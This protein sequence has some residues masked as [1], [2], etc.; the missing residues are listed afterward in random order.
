ME[1]E[2]SDIEVDHLDPLKLDQ[3]SA[4]LGAQEQLEQLERE[5]LDPP[6][7]DQVSAR[8]EAQEQLEPVELH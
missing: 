2:A 3:P 5:H 8:L 7:L 6:E 1:P 4:R